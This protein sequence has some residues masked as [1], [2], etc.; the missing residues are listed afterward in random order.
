MFSTLS[1]L[2]NNA[3]TT[4]D[5]DDDIRAVDIDNEFIDTLGFIYEVEATFDALNQ[6]DILNSVI[7]EYG[8][9]ESLI[10]FVNPKGEIS[11]FGIPSLENFSND[12]VVA[13]EAISE[14]IKNAW[15]AFM[16]FMRELFKKIRGLLDKFMSFIVSERK[17]ILSIYNRVKSMELDTEA[18]NTKQFVLAN[19]SDIRKIFEM[20]ITDII[21]NM[22]V[23]TRNG[24]FGF[25]P[26]QFRVEYTDKFADGLDR[27]LNPKAKV[28]ETKMTLKEAGWSVSNFELLEKN[29]DKVQNFIRS[30]FKAVENEKLKNVELPD[31]KILEQL[32]ETMIKDAHKANL[33]LNKIL[34]NI[35][36]KIKYIYAAYY[37]AIAALYKVHK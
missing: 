6:L 12:S 1:T 25:S 21:P 32:D 14:K 31:D 18:Y 16:K 13:T 36:Q 37:K 10:A 17:Q 22:E 8:C 4:T 5:L 30:L 33:M 15:A 19:E 34:I 3:D 7:T 27:F 11:N 26:K 9:S 35:L 23:T 29:N 28:I 24:I 2:G 20:L